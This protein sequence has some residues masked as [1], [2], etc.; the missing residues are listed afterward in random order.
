MH[1]CGFQAAFLRREEASLL[2]LHFICYTLVTFSIS[3]FFYFRSPIALFKCVVVGCQLG[4]LRSF[5]TTGEIRRTKA[6][7]L[8]CGQC[9]SDQSKWAKWEFYDVILVEK[10]KKRCLGGLPPRL[11]LKRSIRI[12]FVFFFAIDTILPARSDRFH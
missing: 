6:S 9:V 2:P 7:K 11:L 3:N 1:T 10:K 4:N 12:V 8:V 5:R